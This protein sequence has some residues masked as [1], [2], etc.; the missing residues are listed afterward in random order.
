MPEGTEKYYGYKPPKPFNW[1]EASEKGLEEVEEAIDSRVKER[2]E[3]EKTRVSTQ[4]TLSKIE[5]GKSQTYNEFTTESAFNTKERTYDMTQ[6]LYNNEISSLEYRQ[7][8]GNIQQTW[9]DFSEISK[10]FNAD[11][12]IYADRQDNN[13]SSIVEGYNR[14]QFARTADWDKSKM[15][16][17]KNGT[18]YFSK[19]NDNGEIVKGSVTSMGA[20]NNLASQLHDRVDVASEVGRNSKLIGDFKSVVSKT[21][22]TAGFD[23]WKTLGGYDD[24]LK[25]LK[26]R[27][28]NDPNNAAS[29]IGDNGEDSYKYFTYTQQEIDEGQHQGKDM[30]YGIKIVQDENGYNKAELTDDQ[31]EIAG[32]VIENE[33]KA[34]IG[35]EQTYKAPTGSSRSRFTAYQRG[36]REEQKD[37]ALLVQSVVEGREDI[38]QLKSDDMKSIGWDG[39]DIVVVYNTGK[40]KTISKKEN[41]KTGENFMA[42]LSDVG[43]GGRTLYDKGVKLLKVSDRKGV[44]GGD[45]K[46]RDPYKAKGKDGKSIM[47]GTNS[48]TIKIGKIDKT[49]YSGVKGN[50]TSSQEISINNMVNKGTFGY[51]EYNIDKKESDGGLAYEDARNFIIAN[52]RTAGNTKVLT[53]HDVKISGRGKD[54]K[55]T[56]TIHGK[57]HT[58]G[59]G[60]SKFIATIQELYDQGRENKEK[61]DGNARK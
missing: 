41:D 32:D 13:T 40:S 21:Q 24:Y 57:S 14:D 22:T 8:M 5:K 36:K 47:I 28:L 50:D 7:Y 11:L 27:M 59:L 43:Y 60:E 56:I 61:N 35:I 38:S 15:I 58:I 23:A 12:A 49:I 33:L 6:R 30:A 1:F 2:A 19:I 34:Q 54:A 20:I 26:G 3:N 39:D 37:Y 51:S 46:H 48:K 17:D 45:V 25:G 53:A 18:G 44:K 52:I 42:E 16:I 29:V 55:A 4:K 10:N 9:N 31:M